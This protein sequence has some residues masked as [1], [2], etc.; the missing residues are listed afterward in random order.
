MVVLPHG[1]YLPFFKGDKVCTNAFAVRPA[2]G[3]A[4]I[5]RKLMRRWNDASLASSRFVCLGLELENRIRTAGNEGVP[6]Q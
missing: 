6:L 4:E 3:D 5:T 1:L 2:F